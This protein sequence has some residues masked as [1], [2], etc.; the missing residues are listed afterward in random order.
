MHSVNLLIF[1]QRASAGVPRVCWRFQHTVTSLHPQE[2]SVSP[3]VSQSVSPSIRPSVS[4]SVSQSVS[5]SVSPSISQSVRQSVSNLTFLYFQKCPK[6]QI[7][8]GLIEILTVNQSNF[9]ICSQ[10]SLLI[11]K[12]FNCDFFSSSSSASSSSFFSSLPLTPAQSQT[13][14]WQGRL[15]GA[16]RGRV[17]CCPDPCF[18]RGSSHPPPP[19]LPSLH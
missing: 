3:S 17:P 13:G 9:W 7:S 1:P 8:Q 2:L 6:T 16:F 4:P 18:P 14:R 5:Q 10:T 11:F 12:K 19:S 15:S